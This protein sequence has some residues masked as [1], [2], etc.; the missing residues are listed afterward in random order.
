MM[1][2]SG[3]ILDALLGWRR[4][5]ERGHR[6]QVVVARAHLLPR[7]LQLDR[8]QRLRRNVKLGFNLNLKLNLRL[9]ASGFRRRL[10]RLQR[11]PRG[12]RRRHRTF[13]TASN[14]AS[15]YKPSQAVTN[16]DKPLH[17]LRRL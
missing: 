10:P 3:Q 8:R 5:G 4:L 17:L 15:R 16:R 9:Q 6:F 7:F 2:S 12:S 14:E 11:F 13:F 1:T